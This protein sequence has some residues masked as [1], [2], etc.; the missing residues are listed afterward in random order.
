MCNNIIFAVDIQKDFINEDG[1]IPKVPQPKTFKENIKKCLSAAE[2][3]NI[4]IV[5]TLET[6]SKDDET[7]EIYPPHCI[8]ATEGQD[9]IPEGIVHN[10]SFI[11]TV[12]NLGNGIDMSIIEDSWQIFFEKQIDDIWDMEKGQPDNLQ[13]LLRAEDVLEVYILGVNS[14]P[15]TIEGFLKRKYKI[16]LIGDATIANQGYCHTK[17][18]SG[19]IRVIT[20]EEFIKEIQKN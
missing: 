1:A 16:T 8:V 9:I 6:H 13:T 20:T 10:E 12:P 14:V 19:D 17:M 7:F 3:A 2:K 15:S 5:G 18:E 11:Y 4:L